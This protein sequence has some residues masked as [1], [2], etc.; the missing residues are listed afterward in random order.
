MEG[1]GGHRCAEEEEAA[2]MDE[3]EVDPAFFLES[4]WRC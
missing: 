4:V 2:C 1:P 3:G